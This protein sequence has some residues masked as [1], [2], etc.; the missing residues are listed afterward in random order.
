MWTIIEASVGLMCACFPIIGPIFKTLRDNPRSKNSSYHYIKNRNSPRLWQR[1]S[2]S[3]NTDHTL[4][5]E[6][7]S[8]RSKAK[9]DI[10]AGL[11]IGQAHGHGYELQDGSLQD[12]SRQA[13]FVNER[14]ESPTGLGVMTLR[15]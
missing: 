15:G 12:G 4:D 8:L 7:I 5:D 3:G 14:D 2:R 10:A 6:D 11:R 9:G 13:G 1:V